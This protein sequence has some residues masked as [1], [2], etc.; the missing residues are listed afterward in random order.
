MFYIGLGK[1]LGGL[2]AS[3]KGRA[4]EEDS[5]NRARELCTLLRARVHGMLARAESVRGPL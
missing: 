3:L 4:R 5:D 2:P 1:V